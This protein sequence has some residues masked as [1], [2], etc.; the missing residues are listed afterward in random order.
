MSQRKAEWF[1]I[2]F[3]ADTF[4][5]IDRGKLIGGGQ[6]DFDVAGAVLLDESEFMLGQTPGLFDLADNRAGH[7][8]GARRRAGAGL[9]STGNRHAFV[10]SFHRVVEITHEVAAAQLAVGKDLEAELLLPFDYS[11]DVFVFER[12]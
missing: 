2:N 1:G 10:Y 5:V 8:R 3:V 7:H 4:L 6:R 9:P 11:Q 12:A